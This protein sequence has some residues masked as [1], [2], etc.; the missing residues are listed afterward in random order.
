MP[1]LQQTS[2]LDTTLPGEARRRIWSSPDI[3][4]HSL[5]TLT[6]AKI[7]FA[8]GKTKAETVQNIQ[9]GA[10]LEETFG[11]LA[12]VVDLSTITR[13][14]LELITNTLTI[15][16]RA[17]SRT[18]AR[19][20]IQCATHETADEIYS[21]LWR[22]LGDEFEV[23]GNQDHSPAATRTPIIVIVAVLFCTVLFALLANFAADRVLLNGE[24]SSVVMKAFAIVDWKVIGAIGGGVLAI[25]QV[26]L[27]RTLTVPPTQLELVKRSWNGR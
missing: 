13:L 23:R 12:T 14:K 16:Y 21:K 18:P 4:S 3:I 11:P 17:N 25:L 27:Y 9:A 7:Y 1:V 19:V 24:N 15:E 2:P 20:T 26:W 6:L 8:S 5:I 22:R 10:D